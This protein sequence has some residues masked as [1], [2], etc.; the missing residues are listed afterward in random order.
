MLEGACRTTS[1]A[2]LAGASARST[3]RTITMATKVTGFG[4]NAPT[5]VPQ[6]N[7]FEKIIAWGK[8]IDDEK[9]G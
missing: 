6:G 3:P 9:K 1:G 2:F 7:D 4:H 5:K 8:F